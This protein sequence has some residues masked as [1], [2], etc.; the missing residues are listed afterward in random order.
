MILHLDPAII[1][2]DITG[3]RIAGHCIDEPKHSFQL[4]GFPVVV[5]RIGPLT[6]AD[7]AVRQEDRRLDSCRS[8][9][10]LISRGDHP[11]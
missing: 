10:S 1:L 9:G 2:V 11:T 4:D 7:T 6:S 3:R 8:S 5:C